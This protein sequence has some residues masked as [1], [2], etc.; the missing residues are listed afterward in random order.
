VKYRYI[1]QPKFWKNYR[2]LSTNQQN[3]VREAWL[4]FKLD[5]FDTRLRTHRINSLSAIFKR[6]VYAVVIEGD[7]RA[8]F[9]IEEDT[10][11]TVNI[12]SHD[13]YRI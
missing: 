10:V 2:R 4:L 13:I 3:S 7:L 9:Y 5:P 11:V 12:G 1:A 6:T 8:V